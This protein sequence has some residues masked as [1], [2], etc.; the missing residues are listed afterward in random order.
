MSIFVIFAKKNPETDGKIVVQ[1]LFKLKKSASRP[2]YP[3]GCRG[4]LQ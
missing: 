4:H 2:G 3:F 1:G